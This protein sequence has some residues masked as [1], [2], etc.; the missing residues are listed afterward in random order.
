MF[1]TLLLELGHAACFAKWRKTIK[2][3]CKLGMGWYMALA[4]DVNIWMIYVQ[5]GGDVVFYAFNYLIIEFFVVNWR[6]EGM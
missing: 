5:A 6:S 1:A 3:P 4:I 2:N